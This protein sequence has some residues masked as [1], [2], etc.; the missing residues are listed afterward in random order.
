MHGPA[1][2][3]SFVVTGGGF[4]AAIPDGQVIRLL[5]PMGC[6]S[7]LPGV[8]RHGLAVGRKI[9][10]THGR[11]DGNRI[12]TAPALPSGIPGSISSL[13]HQWHSGCDLRCLGQ[14]SCVASAAGHW[15]SKQRQIVVAG[16]IT[17]GLQHV[18]YDG[19]MYI[20][21]LTGFGAG[22]QRKWKP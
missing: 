14:A 22:A 21:N 3:G 4:W 9:L 8:Y 17:S 16:T 18:L 13:Q 12:E 15:R 5:A 1:S 6:H 11:R 2:D 20:N 19:R 10:V 7:E